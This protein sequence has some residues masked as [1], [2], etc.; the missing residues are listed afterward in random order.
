MLV[1]DSCRHGIFQRGTPWA[2]GP[3]M[4]TQC[5]VKP[6][7]NYTYRFNVTDQEGTLW[8]HAHISLL[9]ATVYGA[10]VIRPR[11]GAEAYPFPK[12]HGEET[13]LLGEWWNA[14]VEDL[15]RMA[16]LTGN[17]P[18]NADA[19]TINGKPGDFYNCSNANRTHRLMNMNPSFY[20]VG[21]S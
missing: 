9:R 18:P 16:F 7:G 3:A 21:T 19:Y 17:T 20:H 2:D 11:G 12:P 5:P 6:G 1:L 8:C 14:N 4:V 15:D 10:L 13:V